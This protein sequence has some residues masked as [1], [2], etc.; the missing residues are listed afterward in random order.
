MP[1][2]GAVRFSRIAR[3]KPRQEAEAAWNDKASEAPRHLYAAAI[4]RGR[5][6]ERTREQRRKAAKAREANLHADLGH[7]R[8][9]GEE[10]LRASKARVRT[11]LMRR[12][13]VQRG[14]LPNEMKRRQ[15]YLARNSPNRQHIGRVTDE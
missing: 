14:K 13:A 7:W 11:K 1:K 2:L 5:C 3:R 10:H 6:A 8:T 12:A 9:S 15:S 4:V